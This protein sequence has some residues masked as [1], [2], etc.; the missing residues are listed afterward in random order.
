MIINTGAIITAAGLSS[1]MGDFKPLL[2]IG[3]VTMAERIVST[4]CDA[5]INDIVIV[6]GHNADE[7]ENSLLRLGAVFLRNASYENNEM[8]DSVK[9]GLGYFRNKCGKILIT[10]VDAPL[11]TAD[12][13]K[14][15]LK[16][17]APVAM[18]VFNSKTGHPV[19]LSEKAA[20]D[21]LKYTG[22]GG[23]KG[24]IT[25]LGLEMKRVE[26][27]DGGILFDINTPM[28]YNNT[29]ALHTDRY[30]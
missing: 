9:I 7:L 4:F 2:K 29:I 26:V 3:G 13:V 8:F 18:P 1:R 10:P 23:L 24:A 5:G 28:E 6:T 27:N 21:V 16:N 22:G 14:E 15:L 30:N 20:A 17:D 19:L 11:F 12:T 25:N